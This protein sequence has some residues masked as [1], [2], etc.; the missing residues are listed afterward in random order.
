MSDSDD[1]HDQDESGHGQRLGGRDA[2]PGD[3]YGWFTAD[4]RCVRHPHPTRPLS[5]LRA[6]RAGTHSPRELLI[7]RWFH[8]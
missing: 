6:C 7:S 3:A 2:S 4:H 8:C 5:G 1:Q